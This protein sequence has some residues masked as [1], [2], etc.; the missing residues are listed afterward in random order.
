MY[1]LAKNPEKQSILRQ[2]ILS[3]LPTKDSV[4]DSESM[5]NMP[6]LRACFKESQR[7]EPVLIG[8]LRKLANDVVLGGYKVP[9]D[10]YVAMA[11]SI[12]SNSEKNYERSAEFIPERY[13][14]SEPFPELKTKQPFAFLP[15]GFGPRICIGKRLA[16]LEMEILISK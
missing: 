10:Y 6:Y 13:L 7:I 3:K 11:L 15:F 5:K 1:Q 8:T 16:E 9:K 12:M 2:E 14:K 4:L